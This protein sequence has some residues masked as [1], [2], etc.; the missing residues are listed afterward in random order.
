[1]ATTDKKFEVCIMRRGNSRLIALNSHLIHG[2]FPNSASVE[3]ESTIPLKRLAD[4]FSVDDLESMLA[5][6]KGG[7]NEN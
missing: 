5:Y 4:A 6:R 7:H 2:E 3:Y 1:M